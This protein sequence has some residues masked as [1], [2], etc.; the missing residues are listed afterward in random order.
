[1][2]DKQIPCPTEDAEQTHLFAWAAWAQSKYPELRLMHHIPNGGKRGK[3]E[4]ARLK[5]MGVKPG[6][7]DIF[8]PQPCCQW[9]L[10]DGECHSKLYCGLYIELKRRYGGTATPEQNDWLRDMRAQ[11]YAA[12]LCQGAEAAERVITDYLN[13]EYAPIYIIPPKKEGTK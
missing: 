10:A 4:A 3:A 6:V 11:G 9:Q 5:A 13:G 2:T 7:S 8:L 12:E 1:M